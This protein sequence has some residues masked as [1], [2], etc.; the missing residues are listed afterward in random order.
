M[1]HSRKWFLF[2]LCL[3]L[4]LCL[5]L[6]ALAAGH[7]DPGKGASLTIHFAYDGTDIPNTEFRLFYLAQVDKENVFYTLGLLLIAAALVLSLYN[8]RLNHQAGNASKEALDTLQPMIVP[9]AAPRSEIPEPIDLPEYELNPD[10]PMPVQTINGYGYIGV[11]S[12]RCA[13]LA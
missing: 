11:L 13:L 8:S 4:L 2:P 3:I 9:T 6:Q 7:I 1:K 5:P 10:I 12:I